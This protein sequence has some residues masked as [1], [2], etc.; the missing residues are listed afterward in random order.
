[1]AVGIAV[2]LLQLALFRGECEC[3]H[4]HVHTARGSNSWWKELLS[5]VKRKDIK[6]TDHISIIFVS[7]FIHA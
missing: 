5:F 1:M 6:W 7:T 4:H 3:N 2:L